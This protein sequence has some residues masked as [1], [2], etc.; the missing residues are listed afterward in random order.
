MKFCKVINRRID[1]Y[2]ITSVI[3]MHF[4][5]RRNGYDGLVF[6]GS[7]VVGTFVNGSSRPRQR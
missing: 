2:K 7:D 6:D 3:L 1:I 4:L 5:V